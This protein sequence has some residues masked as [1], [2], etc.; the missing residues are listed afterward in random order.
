[1]KSETLSVSYGRNIFY[2]VVQYLHV[3]MT[4]VLVGGKKRG[5]M[6]ID[7]SNID[8]HI[9]GYFTLDY[10]VRCNASGDLAHGSGTISLMHAAFTFCFQKFPKLRAIYFKDQSHVKCG[11]D[12]LS[13]PTAYLAEHGKT[14]YMAKLKGGLRVRTEIQTDQEQLNAFVEKCNLPC[15]PFE[16]FWKQHILPRLPRVIDNGKM[17]IRDHKERIAKYWDLDSEE[18]T[19][20]KLITLMK[21]NG[22]CELYLHW[23]SGYYTGNAIESMNFVVEKVSKELPVLNVTKISDPYEDLLLKRKASIRRKMEIFDEYIRQH[24]GWRRGTQWALLSAQ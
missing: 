22:E 9:E 13:L 1:M 16:L 14:W 20:K 3:E 23:L 6:Q 17:I 10:D 11:L 15:G 8:G 7:V 2:V 19:I 18:M 24:G 5:C 4:T 12:K 21:A